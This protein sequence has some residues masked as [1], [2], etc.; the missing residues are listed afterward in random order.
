MTID[1]ILAGRTEQAQAVLDELKS[2][3]RPLV[4]QGDSKD[5]ALAFVMAAITRSPAR[6]SDIAGPGKPV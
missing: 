6:W 1:V 3:R 2:A 5:E 4:I